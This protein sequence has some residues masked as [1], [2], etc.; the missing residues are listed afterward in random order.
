MNKRI[1]ILL[2]A[3]IAATSALA[4]YG[5]AEEKKDEPHVATTISAAKSADMYVYGYE[6]GPA[7]PKIVIEFSDKASGFSKDTFALTTSVPNAWGGG[8]SSTKRAITD[9]YSCD[10]KGNK[11]AGATKFVAIESEVDFGV[12]SPFVYD[13]KS[14]RNNWAS[15]YKMTLKVNNGKS[16]TVGSEKYLDGDKFSYTF[17]AEDRVVPQTA[18]WNKDTVT[19]AENGKNI[20]LARASYAPDGITSDSGKNPLVIWLHGAGEGGTDIDIDLLGNEVTGLTYENKVNVQHYF[21]KN[22]LKGAYVLAVQS[23]TMWMDKD[24]TGTYNNGANES[25]AQT[26]YYTEALWKAITTYVDGNSD[27]DKNRIY[28]GGCSNGGYMTMNMMIEHG[29]YF[30]AFYPICEAYKNN[31]IPDETIEKIKN[32]KMWF[33]LSEDDNTVNPSDYTLSLYTRLIAAGAENINLTLTAHVVGQD[34]KKPQTAYL[35]QGHWSWIYA[36]N[37]DVKVKFD[38]SKITGEEYL[39]SANC[40]AAGNMWQWIS[41][42]TK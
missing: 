28:I 39:V 21:A 40:T 17:T 30:A 5:C 42:Q 16:F 27:V 12:A 20:T 35:T 6:W 18:A 31:R 8:N 14:G 26:S 13:M 23:P 32:Y 11:F 38:N 33:L 9:V 19:Y 2:L 7:V 29:D 22:G 1:L 34:A 41:E 36:F 15:D 4:F 37:D 25:G 24:G 3:V 10:E